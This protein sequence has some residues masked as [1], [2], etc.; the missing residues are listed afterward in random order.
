MANQMSYR[1][2]VLTL[3]DHRVEGLSDDDTPI[4]MPDIDLVEV[5]RGKD[6][7]MSTMGTNAK[8]GEVTIR[9][10]PT[11]RT[12]L[13]FMK[14]HSQ[15]QN[16]AV[17]NVEGTWEDVEN[18]YSSVLRGGVLKTAPAG[19]SP[20]KNLEF[21]FEFEEILPDVDGASFDPA[22]IT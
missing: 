13:L 1:Q 18:G 20:G 7:T 11:S 16:G 10:L 17:I 2:S 19:I 5:T 6:G 12:A 4:E 8:G 21:V 14:W 15:M 3:N 22:P 9:L